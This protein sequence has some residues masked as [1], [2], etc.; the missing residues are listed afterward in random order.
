MSDGLFRNSMNIPESKA[1]LV[2][3][4]AIILDERYVLRV[5]T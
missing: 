5:V 1:S 2:A 4:D 3:A